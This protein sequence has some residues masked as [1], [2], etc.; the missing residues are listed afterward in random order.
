MPSGTRE[1][2]RKF[3]LAKETFTAGSNSNSPAFD[4]LAAYNN[5]SFDKNGFGIE[6]KQGKIEKIFF[7]QISP[8]PPKQP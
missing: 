6:T 7:N 1:R 2:K 4:F 8:P 3:I 5:D